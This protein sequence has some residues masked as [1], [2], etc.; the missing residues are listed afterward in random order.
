ML[1]PPALED[2]GTWRQSVWYKTIGE[3]YF[4][5]AFKFAA[6]ADPGAELWYNDYNLEYNEIKTSKTAELVKLVR[7]YGGRIDGVGLQGHLVSESTPT[8]Q[9][10]TPPQDVLDAALRQ[11][12]DLDVDVEYTEV[13][14]RMNTPS[15]PEKLAEQ[16]AAYERVTA[17]CMENDRC[18]GITLWVSLTCPGVVEFVLICS[19]RASPTSTPGSPRPSRARAPRLSGMRSTRRS[20]PTAPCS[21]PFALRERLESGTFHFVY[22]FEVKV[23]DHQC[24]ECDQSILSVLRRF[25]RFAGFVV[26]VGSRETPFHDPASLSAVAFGGVLVNYLCLRL[27]VS[28]YHT[29]DDSVSRMSRSY[30]L[31]IFISLSS[32]S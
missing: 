8:Q 23:A 30:C 3:A 20:L 18:I 32:R 11:F 22:M 26:M 6:E 1:T 14:V 5:L 4:P 29:S 7:Q 10:P 28:L 12:T 24:K 31:E 15:T 16:A 17:S 9:T 21:R 2:D 19:Q 27:E 25:C 13:D